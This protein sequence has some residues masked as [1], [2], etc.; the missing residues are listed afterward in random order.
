[1]FKAFASISVPPEAAP[2]FKIKPEPTPQTTPVKI[3]ARNISFSI[4]KKTGILD[5]KARQP[6]FITVANID[7]LTNLLPFII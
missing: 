2:A 3:V 4:L 7:C 1:M 5:T 6:A